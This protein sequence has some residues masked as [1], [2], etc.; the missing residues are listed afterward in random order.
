[1]NKIGITPEAARDLQ[2]V[3]S[4]IAQ[5]LGNPAAAKRT[6]KSILQHLRVLERFA[7][8]GFSV[9]A[10]TGAD[11]DLRILVCGSYLAPYRVEGKTV[12]IARILHAKQD[13]LLVLFGEEPEAK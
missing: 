12:S 3:Q 13:Y 8:A 10:K 7:N 9:A 5:D 6:V 11:T 4:Y 2:A 1:M